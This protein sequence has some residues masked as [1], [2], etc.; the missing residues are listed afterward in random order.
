MIETRNAAPDELSPASRSAALLMAGQAVVL[1]VLVVIS[2]VQVINGSADDVTQALTEAALVLVFAGCAAALALALHRGKG[3][4]RT[5][6]LV[7]NALLIPVGVSMLGGGAVAI[8]LAVLL[9]AV[10]TIAA[11][12]MM[13]R[14]D[15]DA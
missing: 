9:W 5:P 7:W 12:V 11:A 13:P 2:L 10:A 4:A 1:A 3:L 8:G 14:P 15:L 6:T